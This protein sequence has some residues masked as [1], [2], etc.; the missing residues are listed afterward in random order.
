MM[1]YIIYMQI[2]LIQ[3]CFELG[4]RKYKIISL[5]ERLNMLDL[6]SK[7]WKEYIGI[8]VT[9]NDTFDL[10]RQVYKR[11]RDIKDLDRLDRDDILIEIESNVRGF[12]SPYEYDIYVYDTE[13]SM[14]F[15]LYRVV[16]LPKNY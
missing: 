2:A 15:L 1:T 6:T 13:V 11:I 4:S 7:E 16:I 9:E 3:R 10:N 14:V 12:N 8:E 5:K